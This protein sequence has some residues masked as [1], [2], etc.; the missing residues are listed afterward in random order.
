MFWDF[1]SYINQLLLV[2]R[3]FTFNDHANLSQ[4]IA[5]GTLKVN[6]WSGPIFPGCSQ[7]S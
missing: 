4:Y 1:L 2:R 3:E 7:E 6:I 5:C